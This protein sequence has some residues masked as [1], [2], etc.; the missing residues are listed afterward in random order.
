MSVFSNEKI[1]RLSLGF[2]ALADVFP[3]FELGD[4]AALQGY[5]ARFITFVLSVRIQLPP[6]K[7]GLAS[8]VI[9]VDG[10]NSFN[11]YTVTEIARSNSL[12]SKL[13]LDKIYVSRAFT[14]YQLY[15]LILMKLEPFLNRKK[16]K[17]LIVSDITS[18]FL[19]RDISNTEANDLYLKLCTKLSEIAARKK[20]IVVVSY[21]TEKASRRSVFFEAV[22]HC[23]S[24]VLVKLRKRGKILRFTLES[25]PR[26]KSFSLD[27]PTNDYVQLTD[28]MEV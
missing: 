20:S 2:T 15:S 12:D 10:G 27:L 21:F 19:D 18:L 1:R 8:S 16:S 9:F 25:H 23:R 7:G 4:F 13:V 17:L 28:F 11:L 26:I 6:R 5:A 3:G 14:A 24:N 22:L